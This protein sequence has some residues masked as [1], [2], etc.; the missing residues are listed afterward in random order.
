MMISDIRSTPIPVDD[1]GY[2]IDPGEWSESVAHQMAE[3]E[4]LHLEPDHWR[5]I[6]F[7]RTYYDEHRTPADARFVIRYLNKECG[8]GREAKRRLYQL[9]PYGYVQQACKIAGMKRP[10]IWSTG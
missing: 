4:T 5:V 6:R 9:F 1:E 7:M 3:R 2:L 8:F 10:R